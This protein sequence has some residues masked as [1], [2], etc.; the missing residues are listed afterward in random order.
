M[1]DNARAVA[2]RAARF[3]NDPSEGGLTMTRSQWKLNA[4]IVALAAAGA[5]TVASCGRTDG[6]GD[7]AGTS[8]TPAAMT[9][10]QKIARGKMLVTFGGCN[11][12]HTPGGLYGAPDMSRELAGSEVG[13]TGPWGTSYASNL[14]PDP[15]TGIGNLTEDEIV[16]T[17]RTGSRP[18]KSPLL[19]PMPWP[20]MAA[21]SDEDIHAVAAYLKSI[22]PVKHQRPANV[23][24]GGTPST[25]HSVIAAAPDSA[26][27]AH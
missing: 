9:P 21:L 2:R 5:I 24:P 10:E 15:E 4:A 19:P 25:P 3:E 18:D 1:S 6:T 27:G 16:S 13:W 23:P 26:A 20:N 8:A 14:T 22:P 7:G 17:L 11:D 12:C